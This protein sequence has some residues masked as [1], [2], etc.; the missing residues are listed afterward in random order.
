[1]SIFERIRQRIESRRR[2][3]KDRCNGCKWQ[4]GENCILIRRV[5]GRDRRRCTS[6]RQWDDVDKLLRKEKREE[7]IQVTERLPERADEVLIAYLEK[8]D[9]WTEEYEVSTATYMP[10]AGRWDYDHLK[11]THWMPLPQ[12]PEE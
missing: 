8:Y 5:T 12:P 9:D 4:S 2:R 6:Y 3:E 10:R 7:W 1:M 11:I